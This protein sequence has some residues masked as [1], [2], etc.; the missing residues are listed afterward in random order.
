MGATKSY[1]PK[2][3]KYVVGHVTFE[4]SPPT[5][6]RGATFAL[7]AG[8]ALHKK[9]QRPLFTGHVNDQMPAQLRQLAY[10]LENM[11]K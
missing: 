5:K 6:W 1:E 2:R 4:I 9:D 7:I 11:I 8:E 10:A 3:Q